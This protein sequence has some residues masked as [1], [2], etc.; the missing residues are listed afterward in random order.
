MWVKE[1]VF[2]IQNMYFIGFEKANFFI[3]LLITE[4]FSKEIF[5]MG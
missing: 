2:I 5:I 3:E 1:I 4:D